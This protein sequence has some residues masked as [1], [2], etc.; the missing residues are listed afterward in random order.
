[1]TSAGEVMVAKE[2]NGVTAEGTAVA[3]RTSDG[4]K[5]STS[6]G[7]HNVQESASEQEAKAEHKIRFLPAIY[8]TKCDQEL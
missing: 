3:D 5:N 1:M 7:N 6:D 2:V 4:I 8:T